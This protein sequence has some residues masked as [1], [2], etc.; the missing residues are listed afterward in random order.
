MHATPCADKS[1]T[2]TPGG[3]DSNAVMHH[4]ISN[5][6]PLTS[7]SWEWGMGTARIVRAPRAAIVAR[8]SAIATKAPRSGIALSTV[9]ENVFI[10][11][12]MILG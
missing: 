1:P 10:V 5:W 9:R 4:R 2:T 8:E 12:V 6:S 11:M 3:R 7:G